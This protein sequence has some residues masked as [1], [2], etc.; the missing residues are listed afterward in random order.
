MIVTQLHRQQQLLQYRLRIPT[1]AMST[2]ARLTLQERIELEERKA[3]IAETAAAK[4]AERKLVLVRAQTALALA[5]RG[6]SNIVGELLPHCS[7]CI[8]IDSICINS[9]H[10]S[11]VVFLLLLYISSLTAT[12]SLF[13]SLL[14]VLSCCCLTMPLPP[15]LLSS[16]CCVAFSTAAQNAEPQDLVLWFKLFAI[17]TNTVPQQQ[18]HATSQHHSTLDHSKFTDKYKLTPQDVSLLCVLLWIFNRWLKHP[19]NKRN[20]NTEY[21]SCDPRGY[22][23]VL[24]TCASSGTSACLS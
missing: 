3:E 4:A 13:E 14:I 22:N 15:T 24:A 8:H 7:H 9:V 6:N 18:P 20:S 1:A 10:I 2:L 5:Q 11:S 19:G 17:R 21:Y 23:H 16:L 12:Q